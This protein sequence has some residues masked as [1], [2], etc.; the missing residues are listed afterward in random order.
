MLQSKHCFAHLA[1][2]ACRCV[3]VFVALQR[4]RALVGVDGCRESR[5]LPV[6]FTRLGRTEV[7]HAT[8]NGVVVDDEGDAVRVAGNGFLPEHSL[9]ALQRLG[10]VAE[11]PR[12]VDADEVGVASQQVVRQIFALETEA[13]RRR[14]EN[15]DANLVVGLI[16]VADEVAEFVHLVDG[17]EIVVGGRVEGQSVV[18]GTVKRAVVRV[19]A[20][21]KNVV[22]A[23]A[24]LA[25]SREK[26]RDAVGEQEG[27]VGRLIVDAKLRQFTRFAPVV[28]ESVN[29]IEAR[30]ER[31][32]VGIVATV[33]ELVLEHAERHLRR[34]VEKLLV[35]ADSAGIFSQR[36]LAQKALFIDHHAV[37][38]HHFRR[39]G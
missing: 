11:R 36:N 20:R 25:L 5:V 34:T 2:F 21:H 10:S 39:C 13:R 29:R 31:V 32:A 14:H 1:L 35:G 3:G 22:S 33:A 28:A 19:V 8:V 16:A 18:F 6:K 27:E 15:V 23:E 38:E 7:A 30:R 26:Q 9:I 12:V 24:V 37:D 17:H 4:E